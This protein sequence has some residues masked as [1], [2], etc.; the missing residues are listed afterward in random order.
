VSWQWGQVQ[1]GDVSFLYGR[2]FPPPD[3][4]DPERFPGF[5]GALG[6]DGPI[7]YATNVTITETN[8]P[9]QTP[10]AITIRG[11]GSALDVTLRLDVAS[12]ERTPMSQQGTP[13]TGRSGRQ[14]APSAGLDFL[15]LRGQYTVTGRAGNRTI[16]FTASGS[17]ETFRG[18]R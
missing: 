18:A 1:H 7:A 12:A 13:T 9:D 17:A 2:V 16:D 4:A 5:V 11:R 10:R 8:G 14:G 15:Q 6:P 3:A